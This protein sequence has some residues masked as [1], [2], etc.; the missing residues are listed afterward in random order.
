VERRPYTGTSPSTT[1]SL[2]AGTVVLI[3]LQTQLEL[4]NHFAALSHCTT[5]HDPETPADGT[6]YDLLLVRLATRFFRMIS[7]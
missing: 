7:Y 3:W 2:V 4:L 5:D 1:P 6:V